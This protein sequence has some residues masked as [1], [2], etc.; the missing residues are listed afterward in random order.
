VG[1]RTRGDIH[2]AG[3]SVGLRV[4]Q[5]TTRYTMV[6]SLEQKKE[7]AYCRL[8][9]R[10]GEDCVKPENARYKTVYSPEKGGK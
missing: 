3:K 5:A 6:Y 10:E 1:E 7:I 2:L 8:R 9:Q 4:L